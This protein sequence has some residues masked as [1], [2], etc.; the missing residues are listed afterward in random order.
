M[1]IGHST[2]RRW[3]AKQARQ[4]RVSMYNERTKYLGSMLPPDD[5]EGFAALGKALRMAQRTETALLHAAS[6]L[7]DGQ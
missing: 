4:L 3:L 1:A 7:E 5:N 2:S 6:L